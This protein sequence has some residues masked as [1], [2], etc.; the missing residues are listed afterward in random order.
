MKTQPH[1][2]K[3][4]E[5][6]E[7]TL[8]LLAEPGVASGYWGACTIGPQWLIDLGFPAAFV[9]PMVEDFRHERGNPHTRIVK[10]APDG[11]VAPVSHVRAVSILAVLRALAGVFGADTTDADRQ[12]GR[13]SA[14]RLLAASIKKALEQA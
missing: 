3:P 6:R 12:L 14:A 7:A 2:W 10:Y 11:S 1:Q 13:K 5:L 8:G 4:A 9:L